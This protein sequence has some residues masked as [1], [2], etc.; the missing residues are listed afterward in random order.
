MKKILT[1]LAALV[2]VSEI[3]M[4][5]TLNVVTGNVT[6]QF[7]ASQA[8]D[9]TY[10]D[11]TTIDIM[12]RTFTLSDISEMYVDDTEVTD[13]TV[14]VQYNGTTATVTVAG[15]VAQYVS[16]TVSGAHVS[17][18]QSDDLGDDTGKIEY[19]L[20][21][22]SSD[23]SFYME[24]TYKMDLT[25]DGLTLTNPSGAAIDIQNGKK[26]NVTVKKGTVNTLTDGANGTQ[27]ACFVIKGHAE[28]K[29]QG[30]LNV[31]GNTAHGIKTSDFMTV[32]NLTLNILKAVK[33]GLHANEYCLVESGTLTIKNV[34]DDG[35]QT[36]LDGTTST[37]ETTGHEDEDTGNIYIDGG[38]VNIEA[39]AAGTKCMKADGDAVIN[40]GDITLKAAG[41]IDTTDSSD[42]SYTAGIKGTNV[43]V[44]GGTLDITV[45]GNAGRGLAADNTLTVN[46][47]TI[48]V[49]NSGAGQTISSDNCT[50]KGF[51]ALSMALNSGT[52][53]IT[54]T[55]TGGKGIRVGDGTKTTSGQTTRYTNVTGTFTIGTTDGN[56]PTLTISTTGAQLGSSSGGGG[57]GGGR[58]GGGGQSSSGSSAKGIK[59]ICA[60]TLYGGE[61]VV[62]TTKDGAEGL[63]SKTAVYI[64]GGKH[65]FQCYDDCINSAGKIFFNGGVTV[66]YSNGN[67]SVDSNAGTTGAITIG[68][69]AVFAYT[70]KGAPEE[71]LDCDNNS[72]IQITGTGIGIS[73]GAAQGGGGGGWGGSSSGNTISNAKQ[74]YAFITSSISYS[75]GRY[76]TVADSSGNNLVT[77]SFPTSLSSTLSLITA[78]GMKSGNSYT[79]KYST[80]APTDAATAWHGLYIGS[81]ASGSNNVTSFTAK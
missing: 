18:V 75:A 46:G 17:L 51:K 37:G 3:I 25:L 4:A 60:A 34:G 40:G 32:K 50:A 26:I 79:I 53:T 22:N 70:S 12:G 76:Y 36:E 8:G 15:N 47:G 27:K 14:N 74:G 49:N 78:T 48:T 77:Y 71:G 43:T 72:Y 10:A 7:P 33:D 1:L 63:E 69:G 24:G 30:T 65:Y 73:A 39:T 45:T 19:I 28:I 59:A 44:N 11:G 41:A 68:N 66:C 54:M 67:D 20:T 57:W 31:Y 62:T 16:A 81:T 56:G 64:E 42:L 13:N 21:G 29:G 35:I 23:G 80:T 52:I 2:T 38:T 5:Q 6:Y 58:P 55:G 9:M 61:V